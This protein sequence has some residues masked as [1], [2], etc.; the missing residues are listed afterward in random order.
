MGL[1]HGLMLNNSYT[2][3]KS[4]DTVVI[5]DILIDTLDGIEFI[6]TLRL[7]LIGST[8]FSKTL[9]QVLC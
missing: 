3:I 7:C 9:G 1:Y 6:L 8:D 5:T 2:Y 4:K